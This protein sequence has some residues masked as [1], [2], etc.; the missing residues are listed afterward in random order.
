MKRNC[1]ILLTALAAAA[2]AQI[3]E[4]QE[5]RP[6]EPLA[7]EALPEAHAVRPGV[8]IVQFDDNLLS[9]V[10][11]D[12]AS[13]A[14]QTK[15]T[16]LN[17]MF[18]QLGITSAEPVFPEEECPEEFRQRERDFGLRHFYRVHFDPEQQ[19]V[20]KAS[21]S[22]G[23]IPGIVSA[24]P[25]YRVHTMDFNDPMLSQQ[26][27][28]YNTTKKGADINVK[29][30]WEQ[31][32]TGNPAVIVS[33]V[34][35]GVDLSHEDLAANCLPGGPNGS[36]NFT[37]GSYSVEPMSHGTHV[38]GTIA[39]VS[40]NGKGVAGIAGGNA[41]RG[42]EGVKI[43]SCQFMGTSRDGS[44]SDAIRWGA[45]HGAVIS[46]NSWGYVADINFDGRISNEEMER[47]KN[48]GIGSADRA[49]VDYFR[50]YAGCDANGNQKP[51]SPMKGGLVIFAAGN[52]NI[53]YGPPASYEHILAVGATD[54]NGRRSSFSNYG[55]WVDICAPGSDIMSTYP[56]DQYGFMSGTSMACPHVSGVAALVVSQC[57]GPGFTADMLWTKLVMGGNPNII[58]RESGKNIGP[59]VDAY[60]AILFGDSGEPGII[61]SVDA[62]EVRSNSI[63]LSWVVPADSEGKATYSG[64]I[65]AS[66]DKSAIEHL[67]PAQ[68]GKNVLTATVLTSTMGVGEKATGTISG[69]AFD[70]DYY[71]TVAGASYS[72]S[73]SEP[74][75][76]QSAHTG[77]NHAPTIAPV[78]TV[79]RKNYEVFTIPLEIE[80]IDG[81]ELTV[82]Y[83]AG[84]T[85]DLLRVSPLS[86]LYEIYVDGPAISHGSYTGTV[87]ATDAYG[88][89]A[90]QTVTFVLLE[91]HVPT[92]RSTIDNQILNEPGKTFS[93]KTGDLFADEDGEPLSYDIDVSDKAVLHAILKEDELMVTALRYGVGTVT[94]TATD[95]R[96]ASAR[97]SFSI[98]IREGDREVSLYP[99]PVVDMLSISTGLTEEEV[100]IRIYGAAGNLAYSGR[101]TISAFK[102]AQVDL[103]KCAPGR[104]SVVFTY[105]G[106]PFKE[107][108][109]KQ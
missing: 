18:A 32:T 12:L 9:L 53:Q 42:Q 82:E 61:S 94:V 56:S 36:R 55:D 41:A 97:Q 80:D 65:F 79:T 24:E 90:S 83:K 17:D 52:D 4:Q 27:H 92:V 48:I 25:E 103:S 104:Y 108:I 98:L 84:S 38:A 43:M 72:R 44:A 93:F 8:A 50:R 69:L 62:P 60:A 89:S 102:P 15:S 91:N 63:S 26:W 31:Y 107:T 70:T 23:S 7:A 75:A 13:G 28:Y 1:F 95:A 101:Q 3:A 49:A 10:E 5:V 64:T 35:E 54:K 51:D 14:V 6:Q 16:V 100:D 47:I 33:V 86:G 57:G 39:A 37:N 68:P 66:T 22:L 29:P 2:C 73:Y 74:A 109:I 85:A 58:I 46:Q 78:S 76:F 67:D 21:V 106:K 88:L 77:V 105:E 71:V 87:T 81:H 11:A 59:L 30:V 34:D 96:K 20:T 40:N 19:T 45:N 99:N